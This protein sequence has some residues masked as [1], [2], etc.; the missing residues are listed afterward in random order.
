[1]RKHRRLFSAI[2][3]S[4]AIALGLFSR[5]RLIEFP[6][7]VLEYV[8]DAL[9]AAMVYFMFAFVFAHKKPTFIALAAMLFC[10]GI[11]FS[12]LYH[13]PWID[14][15]RANKLA[16]LVLGQGFKPSDFTCYSIG[17]LIAAIIDRRLLRNHGI[18]PHQYEVDRLPQ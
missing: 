5:S 4:V 17:I 14:A 7:F 11:E 12:Q 6:P 2:A 15:L 18:S 13:A 9:W 1:M 16:A 3:A 10:F 8:G